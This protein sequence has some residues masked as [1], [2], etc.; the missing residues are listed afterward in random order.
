MKLKLSTKLL[1]EFYACSGGISRAEKCIKTKWFFFKEKDYTLEQ[2]MEADTCINSDYAW[3]VS[4][5]VHIVMH[6]GYSSLDLQNIYHAYMESGC[7]HT[8]IKSDRNHRINYERYN[9]TTALMYMCRGNAARNQERR[10]LFLNILSKNHLLFN[11]E[12]QWTL[13][14]YQ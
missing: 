10:K 11:K 9:N 4:H 1:S 5:I 2:L 8:E 12:T 6:N 13:K 3:L 14:F 7:F